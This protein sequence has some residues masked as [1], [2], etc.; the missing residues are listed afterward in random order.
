MQQIEDRLE[1]G[2][3]TSYL[4]DKDRLSCG[5]YVDSG[6]DATLETPQARTNSRQCRIVAVSP[7]QNPEIQN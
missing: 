5:V 4:A 3:D 1:Y 6:C 7:M 2:E